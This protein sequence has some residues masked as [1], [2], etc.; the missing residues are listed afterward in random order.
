MPTERFP[1]VR[2]LLREIGTWQFRLPEQ[3][4][5][6]LTGAV[7]E[8]EGVLYGRTGYADETLYIYGYGVGEQEHCFVYDTPWDETHR[9]LGGSTTVEW[10]DGVKTPRAFRVRYSVAEPWRHV[11]VDP[12]L[13]Q[14]MR[15]PVRRLGTRP[16]V[17]N[18][19]TAG[20]EE[21]LA[22]IE[23][24]AE[25]LNFLRRVR[26]IR[27]MVEAQ[28][29]GWTP[30]MA[31]FGGLVGAGEDTY[32]HYRYK[33]GETQYVFA[34]QPRAPGAE[35]TPEAYS[36]Q[37]SRQERRAHLGGARK[38]EQAFRALASGELLRVRFN[39]GDPGE[40]ALELPPLRPGEAPPVID[41]ITQ[42]YQLEPLTQ[43]SSV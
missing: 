19:L 4:W 43:P 25:R 11:V 9:A 17:R 13:K 8:S 22:G 21:V 37:A 24:W 29:A 16:A 31:V 33:A 35:M 41:P 5:E 1:E 6:R 30:A 27:S 32:A 26:Y 23:G 36:P 34:V 14:M 20:A 39:P 7:G 42:V 18:P 15:R 3:G 10:Y 12:L 2:T 28:G 40:H 38:Q